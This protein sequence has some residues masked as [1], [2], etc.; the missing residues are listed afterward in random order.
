MTFYQMWVAC[1]PCTDTQMFTHDISRMSLTRVRSDPMEAYLH[2]ISPFQ[3][4]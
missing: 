1:S 4:W 2:V 3:L